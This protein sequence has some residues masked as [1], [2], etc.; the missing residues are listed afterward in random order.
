MPHATPL[1]TTIVAGIGLAFVLGAIAHRLRLSPLVGY[2]LAGVVVGPA[3]PGFV[4]DAAL[5]QELAEIG[6]A[7]PLWWSND[8][9]AGDQQEALGGGDAQGFDGVGRRRRQ[10]PPMHARGARFGH[11]ERGGYIAREIDQPGRPARGG[12]EQRQRARHNRGT[13]AALG[14]PTDGEHNTPPDPTTPVV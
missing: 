13:T 8:S 14:G 5:A 6:P 3:T 11:A 1:I 2:L 4:A 12:T 9:P 10:H 7:C